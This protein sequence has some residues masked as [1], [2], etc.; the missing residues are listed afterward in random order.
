ML[1]CE[2]LK[3]RISSLIV[4]F[5]LFSRARVCVRA[6]A[7]VFFSPPPP[8]LSIC[9]FIHFFVLFCLI[10]SLF[11]C[12]FCF[13]LSFFLSLFLRVMCFT[14]SQVDHILER[15]HST[16]AYEDIE[17]ISLMVMV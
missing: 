7:R 6:R 4:R 11:V 12:L 17:D 15:T 10:V 1:F 3:E 9:S 2:L 16:A 5:S 8:N 13:F 14:V